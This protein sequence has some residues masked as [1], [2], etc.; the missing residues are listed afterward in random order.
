[1]QGVVVMQISIH[2]SSAIWTIHF[3]GALIGQSQNVLELREGSHPA[4]QYIPRADIAMDLLEHSTL[5]TICPHKG[6]ASYFHIATPA[7]R[8]ENAVWSYETPKQPMGAIAGYLAFQ[9]DHVILKC[10][11]P[12]AG[13]TAL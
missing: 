13:E 1:V 12:A 7:T 6:L 3:G 4:V 2:P 11:L 9:K 10:H 8:V 5:T